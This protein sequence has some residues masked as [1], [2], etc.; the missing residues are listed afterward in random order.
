MAKMSKVVL[1]EELK[2]LGA[3][4]DPMSS[5]SDLYAQLQAAKAG[6]P[7]G[8]GIGAGVMGGPLPDPEI[9]VWEIADKQ[10]A[11]EDKPSVKLCDMVLVPGTP[12]AVVRIENRIPKK[13]LFLADAIRDERDRNVLNEELRKKCYRGR[14]V[15]VTTVKH[16]EPVDDCWLT[17]FEIELK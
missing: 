14:I 11:V 9:H 7:A 5:Y 12:P 15:K 8:M 3:M 17:E 13:R 2:A 16:Y 4:Y 10:L 1:I 6:D